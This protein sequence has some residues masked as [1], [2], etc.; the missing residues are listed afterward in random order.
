MDGK[1]AMSDEFDPYHVWLGI[2]AKEQPPNHYRLLGIEQFEDNADVIDAATNRQTHY[3]QTMASGPRRKECQQLLDEIAAARICLLDE[4]RKNKYDDGLRAAAQQKSADLSAPV[5]PIIDTGEDPALSPADSG[6]AFNPTSTQTEGSD[7]QTE[8]AGNRRPPTKSAGRKRSSQELVIVAA[9]IGL[10]AAVAGVLVNLPAPEGPSTSSAAT[11]NQTETAKS[12]QDA[13]IEAEEAGVPRPGLVLWL[14]ASDTSTLDLDEQNRV[15]TW[16]EKSDRSLKPKSLVQPNAQQRPAWQERRL[17]QNPAVVFSPEAEQPIQKLSLLT[18]GELGVTN[19]WTIVFLGTGTEGTLL[20]KGK[21]QLRA[22]S[23]T[24]SM[25]GTAKATQRTGSD[26]AQLKIRIFSAN[27]DRIYAWIDGERMSIGEGG[28]EAC[29]GQFPF[30]SG[31]SLDLGARTDADSPGY[32]G[33]IAELLIYDR[34]LLTTERRQLEQYL[35]DKWFI[36]VSAPRSDVGSAVDSL[37]APP[38]FSSKKAGEQ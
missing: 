18:A 30:E 8:D 16:R 11:R 12:Q 21:F 19:E 6:W 34:P 1:S 5:M 38:T 15:T 3:L 25:S 13:Q 24:V 33:M 35:T 17:R 23:W 7:A 26:P 31:P 4:V 37:F 9:L 36:A 32:Q 14:D 20:R 27:G 28:K 29:E 2:P 10:I 22:E